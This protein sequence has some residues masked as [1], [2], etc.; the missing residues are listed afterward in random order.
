MV[1]DGWIKF[2]YF[3]ARDT[4]FTAN[5]EESSKLSEAEKRDRSAKGHIFTDSFPFI[6]S[7]A[8]KR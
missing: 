1:S 3:F 8:V 7:E 2:D 4:I 6:C 5:R